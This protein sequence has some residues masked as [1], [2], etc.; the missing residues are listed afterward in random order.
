MLNCS[1]SMLSCQDFGMWPSPFG[2]FWEGGNLWLKDIG[3]PF[4]REGCVD[5]G[6]RLTRSMFY[7]KLS[8]IMGRW[9]LSEGRGMY[10]GSIWD[11]AWSTWPLAPLPPP[12]PS[13]RA[14]AVSWQSGQHKEWKIDILLKKKAFG[15]RFLFV[16]SKQ[17]AW[18]DHV[19]PGEEEA[20]GGRG[21][22]KPN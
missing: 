8:Y 5:I 4:R 12:P 1:L 13:A 21:K 6:W 20:G 18:L 19:N 9:L 11:G 15:L 22:L 7:V 3:T 10:R 16:G 17:K 14:A 2:S